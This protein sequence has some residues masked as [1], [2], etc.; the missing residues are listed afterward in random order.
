MESEMEESGE[1]HCVWYLVFQP[2]GSP[3]SL[4]QRV[5]GQAVD[6]TFWVGNRGGTQTAQTH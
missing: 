4:P 2:Q 5:L 1:S 3:A 6:K